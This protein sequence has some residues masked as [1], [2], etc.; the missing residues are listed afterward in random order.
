[1][2]L[3]VIPKE[4]SRHQGEDFV[5]YRFENEKGEFDYEA[6]R[7][8]QVEGNQRKLGLVWAQEENIAHLAKYL[9]EKLGTV[10]RGICH[11]TRRGVEQG[12]FRQYLDGADVIG[13]EIA[14]TGADFPHTVVWDFHDEKPEWVGAF[15]FV[16]SNSFDHA[17]DPEKCLTTW[18]RSLRPGGVCLLEWGPTSLPRESKALDPFGVRVEIFPFLILRWGKGTYAARDVLTMPKQL[19]TFDDPNLTLVVG[20]VENE[21]VGITT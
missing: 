15:D 10:R 19:P 1:M 9:K 8:V 17:Y 7:K 2:N 16:Y 13:T 5:L 14:E 4:K 12:W 11:G 21:P 6:Y 3:E 20:R 18:V